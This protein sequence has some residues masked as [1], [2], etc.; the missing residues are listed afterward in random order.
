MQIILVSRTKK[1]PKTL[2]LAHRG[3]RWR[4]AALG[5]M[6]V[7]GVMALGAA[8]ALTLSNPRDRTLAQVQELKQQVRA[9]QDKLVGVRAD[10]QPVVSTSSAS[11][12]MPWR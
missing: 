10:A 12:L 4:L 7:C 1:V 6:G 8:L 11:A 2:D 9:Q 3:L 5:V